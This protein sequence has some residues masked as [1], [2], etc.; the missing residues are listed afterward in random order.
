[1]DIPNQEAMHG[2]KLS[3]CHPLVILYGGS[4]R[5]K[6]IGGPLHFLCN[7]VALIQGVFPILHSFYDSVD[8]AY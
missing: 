1:V 2:G 5:S 6:N 8:L 4:N 7:L 3:D